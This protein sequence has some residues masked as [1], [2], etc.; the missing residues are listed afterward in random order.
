VEP[1]SGESLKIALE[2]LTGYG[3]A[4]FVDE[5]VFENGVPHQYS[6][7]WDLWG[8]YDKVKAITMALAQSTNA[9]WRA[10]SVYSLGQ[11]ADAE[12]NAAIFEKAISDPNEWVRRAAAQALGRRAK[13][14]A[15]L[16]SRLGPMLSDTNVEVAGVAAALLLEPEVRQAA[17][18]EGQL[19]YF[20]F[21]G[22]YGGRTDIGTSVN[23]NNE[24]PLAPLEGKPA[25]LPQAAKWAAT[26]KGEEAAPFVVL[27]AQ[28]G[29]FDGLDH[30]LAQNG[31]AKEDELNLLDDAIL[32]GIALS[33]D[34]KYLPALRKMTAAQ[35]NDYQL[36]KILQAIQGMRGADARQLRLDI[37][38]K[39]RTANSP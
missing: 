11:R 7:R 34:A 37:N 3:Q 14:H 29:Q 6:A 4:S 2:E 10:A 31:P 24:R 8:E 30:L 9:A 1:A 27:L 33:Q 23:Q 35:H 18:L 16:E 17:G 32:T 15:A 36:R 12:Q 21:D 38:K 22:N 5:T 26:A 13:D 20:E 39:L 28:Y 19:N 25:F